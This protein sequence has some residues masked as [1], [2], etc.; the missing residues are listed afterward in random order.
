MSI[1]M[2]DE[3]AWEFLE[4]GHTGILTTLQQDGWPVALPVWFAVADHSI[5][6]GTPSQTK[7]LK[8]I[9]HDER[10]SFLVEQGT[11]WAELAAVHLPV[12]ARVLDP[13]QDTEEMK[14]AG[15]LF[16]EK[17]APFRTSPT[18]LPSATSKHYSSQRIIRLDAA[19]PPVSWDNARLRFG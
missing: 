7:K 3:E 5:Y 12:L 6:I 2:S 14:R 9:A 19:G 15:R 10:A 18:K 17:Y 16:A 11:L 4:H 8:R 1:S 13:E